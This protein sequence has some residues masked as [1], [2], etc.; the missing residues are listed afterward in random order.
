MRFSPIPVRILTDFILY[1]SGEGNHSWELNKLKGKIPIVTKQYK[2]DT[3]V[4]S[5]SP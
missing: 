2:D 1:R 5:K 4:Y 3:V